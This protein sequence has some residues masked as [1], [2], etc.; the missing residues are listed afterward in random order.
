MIGFGRLMALNLAVDLKE[1]KN[2]QAKK[3]EL[4]EREYY[5]NRKTVSEWEE[6]NEGDE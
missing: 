6:K 3:E 4:A 2:E 1:A 5:N